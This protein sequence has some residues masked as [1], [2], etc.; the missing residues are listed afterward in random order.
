MDFR[1]LTNKEFI[2]SFERAAASERKVMSFVIEHVRE[3]MRREI[4]EDVNLPG[5]FEFAAKNC[6]SPEI[7]RERRAA[8]KNA[9]DAREFDPKIT[10]VTGVEINPT[11]GEPQ[12]TAGD[13]S[14]ISPQIRREVE[15]EQ[16]SCRWIYVDI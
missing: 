7:R 8:K 14:Y 4:Y 3:G 5:I 15:Q 9:A 2:F 6:L 1:A 13:P 16:P 11:L 12:K 10:P